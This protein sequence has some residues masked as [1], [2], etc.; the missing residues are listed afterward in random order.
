[1]LHN[2]QIINFIIIKQLDLDFQK[3]LTVFTGETGAGKSIVIDALSLIL[4]ARAD[5]NYIGP[6]QERCHLSATFAIKNIPA[7][8]HWLTANDYGDELLEECI[9]SRILHRDGKSKQTINGYQCTAQQLKD[10]LPLLINLH[11]QNQYQH[12]TKKSFQRELLDHFAQHQ[13]RQEKVRQSFNA[14]SSN[15]KKLAEILQLQTNANAQIELA[16]Y[17]AQEFEKLKYQPNE[18]EMLDKEHKQLANSEHLLSSAN[19]ALNFLEAEN[20]SAQNYL[21]QA[22]NCL[23]GI[24]N[25]DEKLTSANELLSNSIIHLEEATNYIRAYLN[26]LEINPERLAEIELRLSQV[27]TLARKYHTLPQDLLL[28]QQQL[29]EKLDQ[30][31]NAQF[32]ADNLKQQAALLNHD[33]QIEAD[34]LHVKRLAAAKK[35][36]AVITDKIQSLGMP[37]ARF[38][39]SVEKTSEL[40]AHGSDQIEFLVATNP[41]QNLAPLSKVASGGEISRIA[42]AIYVATALNNTTPVCVFDEVDVGIGGTTAAIVGNL[43][44]S[45]GS[46]CQVICITHLPQVAAFGDQHFCVQKQTSKK[47]TTTDIVPL[48]KDSRVLELA[49]MLGGMTITEKTIEHAKELLV[50]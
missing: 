23:N 41:G 10:F 45:L 3:G 50:N 22:Q 42:L 26:Q 19:A 8:Q 9:V 27:H 1:M 24:A 43:L 28:T 36:S 40:T 31:K 33:Y 25:Y 30:L 4:G 13:D 6:F 2:L 49:R 48:D 37:G 16:E 35:L 47:Q 14:W 18:Y 32:L 7:A 44:K 20:N 34:K 38:Q 17:Q 21:Y 5:V 11:S 12:L 15:E 46:H 39:I 29:L